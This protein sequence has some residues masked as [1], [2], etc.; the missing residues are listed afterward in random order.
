MEIFMFN[1]HYSAKII[2]LYMARKQIIIDRLTK[3]TSE[4]DDQEIE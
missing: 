4:E 3:D 2:P 1:L